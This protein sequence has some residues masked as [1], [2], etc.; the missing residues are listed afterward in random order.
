MGGD[1]RCPVCQATFTRPQHVA[2][3]MRSR[4]SHSPAPPANPLLSTI[5]IPVIVRTSANTVEIN[6]QEGTPGSTILRSITSFFVFL[7]TFLPATSTNVTPTKNRLPTPLQA[8]AERAQ[9]LPPARPPPSRPATS[10]S[11]PL[12]LATVPTHAVRNP[13]FPKYRLLTMAFSLFSR[14]SSSARILQQNVLPASVVA[15]MSN[16]TGKPLLLVLVINPP[17]PLPLPRPR[18]LAALDLPGYHLMRITSYLRHRCPLYLSPPSLPRPQTRY[19]IPHLPLIPP[20]LLTLQTG[21]L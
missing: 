7:A 2:R 11:S 3:H 8:L 1:H 17:D 20:P 10:V 6:L 5:Q 13:H 15:P 14:A 16:F 19:S 9:P 18:S 4:T 21:R 12:S